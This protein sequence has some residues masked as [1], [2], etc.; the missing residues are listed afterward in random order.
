LD[1][2]QTKD[3]D[4]AISDFTEAIKLDPNYAIAYFDRGMVYDETKDY[5][6]AIS[7]YT[8]AIRLDPFNFDAYNN[9]GEGQKCSSGGRLRQSKTARLPA[10]VTAT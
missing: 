10:E 9:R 8:Q 1:F 7:D 6:K 4:K 3:Y 5:D 2:Y